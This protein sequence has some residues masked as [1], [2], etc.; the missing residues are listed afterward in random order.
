MFVIC[1]P[2]DNLVGALCSVH[3][4]EQSNSHWVSSLLWV[5]VGKNR[6]DVTKLFMIWSWVMKHV[7]YMMTMTCNIIYMAN[8]SRHLHDKWLAF[9]LK[10]KIKFSPTSATSPLA[11]SFFVHPY[12]IKEKLYSF[13]KKEKKKRIFTL[14]ILITVCFNMPTLN[15]KTY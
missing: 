10:N 4:L 14:N 7:K 3:D 2:I 12:K 9:L 13:F 5:M 1:I 6:V 11:V 15:F 8:H